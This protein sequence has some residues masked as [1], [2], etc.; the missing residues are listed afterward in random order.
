[1]CRGSVTASS[2]NTVGSPNAPSASRIAASTEGRSI[3]GRSTRRIPRPP[4]PATALT[5]TGNVRLPVV[6]AQISSTSRD[7]AMLRRTGT[8]AAL[9]AAT[10][11][12]LLPVSRSTCAGRTDERDARLDA[13]LGE[14]RVLGQEAVTGIDRLGARVQGRR[15]DRGR[16]QVGPDRVAALT[17]LVGLVGLQAM[18]RSPVLIGEDR[19]RPGAQLVRRAEGAHGDL[20]PVGHQHLG[21]HP[22]RLLLAAD[23]RRRVSGLE[24]RRGYSSPVPMRTSRTPS[25]SA[26]AATRN[27]MRPRPSTDSSSS[28][29]GRKSSS[30]TARGWLV[31]TSATLNP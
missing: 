8:P 11:L 15:D 27:S 24:P 12:D 30:P 26:S 16:V 9:A 17:D 22:R 23:G 19:D 14:G 25:I 18:L 6:A 10:A 4:P 7:G 29:A 1:M 13:G 5:K 21:E 2:T 31:I 20:A 3:S 28:T